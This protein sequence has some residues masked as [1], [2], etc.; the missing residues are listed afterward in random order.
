MLVSRTR[1]SFLTLPRRAG[2][3]EA[4]AFA[5]GPRLGSAPDNASHR[6]ERCVRGTRSCLWRTTASTP[7][8]R[9]QGSNP[10]I[11]PRIHFWIA[12]PRSQWRQGPMAGD[13]RRRSKP[14]AFSGR[15]AAAGSLLIPCL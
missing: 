8:L 5:D 12:S 13:S 2:T 11:S 15:S 14:A 9:A 6:R 1:C 10:G 3:Q 4:T 7:S